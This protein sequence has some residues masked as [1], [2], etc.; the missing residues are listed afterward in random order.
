MNSKKPPAASE[1]LQT[2][3]AHCF[4]SVTLSSLLLQACSAFS[5]LPLGT[6]HVQRGTKYFYIG[7]CINCNNTEYKT[8]VCRY[9]RTSNSLFIR[10]LESSNWIN[11]LT[12]A[13]PSN[14]LSPKMNQSKKLQIPSEHYKVYFW[15]C[16]CIMWK[17]AQEHKSTKTLLFQL[18]SLHLWRCSRPG[19]MGSLSWWVA[20]LPT[21][22]GWNWMGCRVPSNPSHAVSLW[23]CTALTH[24]IRTYLHIHLSKRES[25][26][27][28]YEIDLYDRSF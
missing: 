2:N 26:I 11:Y 12:F 23:L 25:H 22:R 9:T 21:A 10:K 18:N 17:S 19:W 8:Y 20:A 24:F 6:G 16:R 5:P 15:V 4:G 1:L 14:F 13:E 27:Y 3:A 28:I 7:H